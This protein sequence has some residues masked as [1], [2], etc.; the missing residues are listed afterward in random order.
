MQRGRRRPPSRNGKRMKGKDTTQRRTEIFACGGLLEICVANLRERRVAC[1][2]SPP[3]VTTHHRS[4]A[5]RSYPL[6]VAC[7]RP[8]NSS[9]SPSHLSL[10]RTRPQA[11]AALPVAQQTSMRRGSRAPSSTPMSTHPMSTR[12]R[13]ALRQARVAANEHSGEH[14]SPPTS[15]SMSTRPTSRMLPSPS[16]TSTRRESC[17]PTRR[18]RPHVRRAMRRRAHVA[19]GRAS[20][21]DA[22]A[23]KCAEEAFLTPPLPTSM[24]RGRAHAAGPAIKD[25]TTKL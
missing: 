7:Y 25:A 14:E 11:G 21:D 6:V 2:T 5:C 16:S 20:L 22:A 4:T 10:T 15:T 23:G 1:S 3:Y 18:R 17:A 8:H 9:L 13:R 19:G 12:C 24:R